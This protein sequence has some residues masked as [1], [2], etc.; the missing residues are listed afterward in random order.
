MK[1][2]FGS[3]EAT[4]YFARLS[5]DRFSAEAAHFFATLNAIHPFRE[6]NGRAQNAFLGL[7]A[8]RAGQALSLARLNPTVFRAAMVES[9]SG[10]EKPLADQIRRMIG[11]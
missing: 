7:L 10:S 5:A 4:D 3:L 1:P 8:A 6:G 11:H 2:L 9:F